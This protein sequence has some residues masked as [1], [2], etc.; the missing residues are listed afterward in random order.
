VAHQVVILCGGMGQ[1]LKPITDFIPKPMVDVNGKP[2]L[3]YLINSLD[4]KLIDQIVLLTGYKKNI[5]K[6]YFKENKCNFPTV[7][8]VDGKDSWSTSRRLWEAKILLRD[9]FILLY[10]DNYLT[11]NL[12]NFESY[13]NELGRDITLHLRYTKGTGNVKFDKASKLVCN[14]DK[15]AKFDYTELGYMFVN[16]SKIINTIDRLG[17]DTDF[18]DILKLLVDDGL[19]AGRLTKDFFLTI[20]D[21]KMLDFARSKLF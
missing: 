1:R 14:Y 10:G 20:T 17:V 3:D 7:K 2:F 16:K 4:K 6:D 19:V 8:V 15:D 21:K 12:C 13:H 18:S 11:V 5:I 9:K